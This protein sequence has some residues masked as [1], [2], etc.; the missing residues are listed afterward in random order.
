[1]NLL[2]QIKP[3]KKFGLHSNMLPNVSGFIYIDTNTHSETMLLLI[4]NPQ[5]TTSKEYLMKQHIS[6]YILRRL[7]MGACL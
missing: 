2:Y 4:Q 7:H 6:I 1:M 5:K 3:N